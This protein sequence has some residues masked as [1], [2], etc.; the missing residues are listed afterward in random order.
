LLPLPE[1]F[2]V[3]AIWGKSSAAYLN[4]KFNYQ[5]PFQQAGP[6]L[7]RTINDGINVFGMMNDEKRTL[8]R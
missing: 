5:R 3:A 1:N 2:P 4:Q 7:N 6:G 8:K